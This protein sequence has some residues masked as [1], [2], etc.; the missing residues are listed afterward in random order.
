MSRRLHDFVWTFAN[1]G[2]LPSDSDQERLRKALLTVI[3]SCM[4]V[5]AIFWGGIYSAAGFPLSG[6]IP[7]IYTAASAL[8]I[9]HYMRVKQF[10]FFRLSQLALILILPFLLQL[11]LGGFANASAVTIWAFFA[12][13]AALFF[14]NIRAAFGWLLAFIALSVVAAVLEVTVLGDARTVSKSVNTA[15]FVLNMSCGFGLIYVVLHYFVRDLEQSH[16][17]ALKSRED[18]V[19]SKTELELAYQRLQENEAKIR[20]L[21]LTDPLT[22]LPNRRHLDQRLQEEVKRVRRFGHSVCI[23]MTD[24][25]H[26]K[27]VNDTFG[28]AVGDATLQM[29]S[30]ILQDSVR[31]VD[32]VARYGGEEFVLLLPETMMEGATQLAERIR[33]ATAERMIPTTDQKMSASFGVTKVRGDETIYD[34]LGRAD[35]ALYKAKENGRNRVTCVG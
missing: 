6:A 22:G 19:S 9:S 28:H 15:F 31:S 13:L 32:F 34:A 29:F 24:L 21:M 7:L 20:E 11:S 26:F 3:A 17:V 35:K 33:V 10:D 2:A 27:K 14:A 4:A 1:K 12:P 8:S 18:A 5:L 16:A 25:D 23:V 30:H